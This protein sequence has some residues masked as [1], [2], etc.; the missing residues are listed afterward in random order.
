MFNSTYLLTYL[1]RPTCSVYQVCFKYILGLHV[2]RPILYHRPICMHAYVGLHR[3][4]V[5][6]V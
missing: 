3:A 1:L 5:Y 6:T 4:Y 2:Y